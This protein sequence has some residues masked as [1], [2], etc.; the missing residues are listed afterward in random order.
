MPTPICP[1]CQRETVKQIESWQIS[2]DHTMTEPPTSMWACTDPTCLHK[3]PRTP[4]D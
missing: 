1:Q 4:S 3:W 2:A